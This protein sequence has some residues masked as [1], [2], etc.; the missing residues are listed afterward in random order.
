MRPRKATLRWFAILAAISII[1]LAAFGPAMRYLRRPRWPALARALGFIY[2]PLIGVPLP[3]FYGKYVLMWTPQS[4]DWTIPPADQSNFILNHMP[5]ID[6]ITRFAS[7]S[8]AGAGQLPYVLN[9]VRT[10][11]RPDGVIEPLTDQFRRD[12]VLEA[13]APFNGR[14]DFPISGYGSDYT[15]YSTFISPRS[16]V[17]IKRNN[18]DIQ[19]NPAWAYIADTHTWQR[20]VVLRGTVTNA[21]RQPSTWQLE[22]NADSTQR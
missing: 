13:Q 17:P 3:A 8:T 9:Q 22:I 7:G 4:H 21:A 11:I 12:G 18:M 1:Y 16:W 10:H 20:I 6:A 19:A 15:G 2:H 14:P 5:D